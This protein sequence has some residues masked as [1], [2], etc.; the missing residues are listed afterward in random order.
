MCLFR[1]YKDFFCILTSIGTFRLFVGLNDANPVTCVEV[2]DPIGENTGIME[3]ILTCSDAYNMNKISIN[4]TGEG[5][6]KVYE[7]RIMGMN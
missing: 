5:P 4:S 6:L 2:T 7:I 1:F 3:R